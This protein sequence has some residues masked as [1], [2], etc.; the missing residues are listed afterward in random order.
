MEKRG[1][2]GVVET[3]L[4]LMI[5]VAAVGLLASFV[6]PFVKESLSKSSECVGME[7]IY[8]FDETFELN[9]L[10]SGVNATFSVKANNVDESKIAGFDVV[11]FGGGE[12]KVI[13]VRKE[14]FASLKMYNGSESIT[15]QKSGESLT[16]AYYTGSVNYSSAEL[17]TAL[18]NGRVCEAVNDKITLFNC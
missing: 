12:S 3:V 9:C 16:Y 5:T 1:L 14:G 10:N 4:I 8:Q 13:K 7:G 17:R 6:I 15:L 18:Q 11:I 2:S